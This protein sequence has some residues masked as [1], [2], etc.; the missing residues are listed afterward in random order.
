MTIG[1]IKTIIIE[2]R[3]EGTQKQ[4]TYLNSLKKKAVKSINDTF[5]NQIDVSD[6]DEFF[7]C[8]TGVEEPEE[9]CWTE[10][11]GIEFINN[12][13]VNISSAIKFLKTVN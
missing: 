8:W 12:K 11:K 4:T 7:A 6:F 1:K 2:A 10:E 13:M 3:L 9:D 5:Q